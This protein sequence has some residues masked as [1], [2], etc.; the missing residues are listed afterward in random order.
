MQRNDENKFE[1]IKNGAIKQKR[2]IQ[3]FIFQLPL[4]VIKLILGLILI[5][6]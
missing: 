1:E 4:K 2:V 6:K 5:T 3:I